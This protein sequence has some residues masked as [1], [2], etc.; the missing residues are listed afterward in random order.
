MYTSSL[1]A[2]SK[3]LFSTDESKLTSVY[4]SYKIPSLNKDINQ[5][6]PSLNQDINYAPSSQNRID[7]TYY[8]STEKTN[9]LTYVSSSIEK[10]PIEL[11]SKSY[12]VSGRKQLYTHVPTFQQ[13]LEKV[14]QNNPDSMLNKI[15]QT[16]TSIN[17]VNQGGNYRYLVE[18]ISPTLKSPE[19]KTSAE[20]LAISSSAF[21]R[22]NLVI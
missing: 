16:T 13:I 8:P 10:A 4:T 21:D 22:R 11:S 9:E 15:D 18:G 7:L 1:F 12:E 17:K 5:L 2:T 20:E 14:R 6:P 19:K 3:P